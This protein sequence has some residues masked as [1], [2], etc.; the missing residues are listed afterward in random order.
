MLGKQ[1][2]GYAGEGS[3]PYISSINTIDMKNLCPFCENDTPVEVTYSIVLFED[4]PPIDGLVKGVCPSCGSESVSAEQFARNE[5][6]VR[7]ALSS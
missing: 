2:V 3:L 5:K 1:V 7:N 6:V 4:D